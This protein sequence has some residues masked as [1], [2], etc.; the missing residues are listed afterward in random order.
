MF[1]LPRYSFQNVRWLWYWELNWSSEPVQLCHSVSLIEIPHMLLRHFNKTCG[2]KPEN[3]LL[4]LGQYSDEEL[5]EESGK[6]ISHDTRENS[7]AELD[8]Q[9]K[10][11][12]H[13]G[14]EVDKDENITS[15]KPD[16]E[17]KEHSSSLDVEENGVVEDDMVLPS[18]KDMDEVEQ[19]TVS[20]TSD[21]QTENT[22]SGWK[23]VLHEESNSYYYW[24]IATGQTS[25]EVPVDL[26]QGNEPAYDPQSVTEVEEMNV[27]SDDT[28]PNDGPT[29]SLVFEATDNDSCRPEL[30]VQNENH[31]DIM[32]MSNDVAEGNYVN[33]IDGLN[34]GEAHHTDSL[35]LLQLG[36]SLSERLKSL[37][38]E[39][40]EISKL[41]IELD[42]RLA[43]IK[44]LVPYGSSLLPFWLHSENH[45]RKLESAINNE[46]L[47]HSQ[48]PNEAE[49]KVEENMNEA[50]A[51]EKEEENENENE[52]AIPQADTDDDMDVEMEVEDEPVVQNR[53]QSEEE[54]EIPPPP[55]DE[56]VPPPP[57]DDEPLPPPPPDEQPEATFPTPQ[58][59]S[60]G[61]EGEQ[62]AHFAYGGP[63]PTFEYYGQQVVAN[64]DYYVDANG[65][66]LTTLYYAPVANPP[67]PGGGGTDP[68]EHVAYYTIQEG[69][70]PI[71]PVI[72]SDPAT[73]AV[74]APTE[75]SVP[76]V[77]PKVVRN[78]KRTVAA[79]P[80]LRSNKKVSG[81][82][83]KW[84]AVKEELHEEEE[85]ENA[86]EALEKK[87][88]R[89]I[90]QWRAQQIATGEAKDNAN[91]Q[92][93]G[94]DWRERVRRKR[95]KKS[96]EAEDKEA[97]GTGTVDTNQKP[98]LLQ[99]T[100]QLP[101]PWQAYW[102]EA[103]KQVYYGNSKTSETSWTKPQP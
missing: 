92:P 59:Y 13:E 25:W 17:N 44:S 5:E 35:R 84:K 14:T 1:A 16:Q 39:R 22:D 89:G 36:E 77:Q 34:N 11:D 68:G 20:W 90:E 18:H 51:S 95:A 6:E 12:S 29:K 21:T 43:D 8:E 38:G 72:G 46:I 78:K 74:S 91:F 23:M 49:K 86:L 31:T 63:G 61:G 50:T 7:P 100:K 57:P 81:L 82:V 62:Y 30:Q 54:S 75:P 4:L 79:V 47:E 73:S 32:T 94:G 97:K 65:A 102:D 40:E 71:Q 3:P 85:P 98:D 37:E 48:S 87:K 103:S 83:D 45:L 58:A 2:Q 28:Q 70:V 33:A 99:L 15:E 101:S 52:N 60:Y 56:W 53:P 67:Y 76:K 27:T 69:S 19:T 64:H 96:M 55:N 24:N 9:V 41:M 80:G 93:L 10:A 88:Q 26:V 42:V 66:P